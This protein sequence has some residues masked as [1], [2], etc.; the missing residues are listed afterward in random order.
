MRLVKV[1]LG[2]GLVGQHGPVEGSG[3]QEAGTELM[4]RVC[5]LILD[6]NVSNSRS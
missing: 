2:Q 6:R 1:W 5:K 4:D 3:F